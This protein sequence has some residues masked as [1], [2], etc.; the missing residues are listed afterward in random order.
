MFRTGTGSVCQ[1]EAKSFAAKHVSARSCSCSGVL[2]SCSAPP[3]EG[4]DNLWGL[5][6]DEDEPKKAEASEAFAPAVTP[7]AKKLK[8]SDDGIPCGVCQGSSKD[9]SSL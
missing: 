3:P 8:L 9:R 6:F 1:S 4:D 7:P 5:L 2:C